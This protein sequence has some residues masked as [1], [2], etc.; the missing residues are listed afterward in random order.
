MLC[1]CVILQLYMDVTTLL[2]AVKNGDRRALARCIS[3]VENE[4]SEAHE[5]LQQLQFTK[6]VPIVGITG[7]PGAG[8]STLISALINYGRR[9]NGG[10][11]CC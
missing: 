9:K 8:K 10:C 11:D 6:N 5:I 7:P 1:F 3:L 4:T 2:A